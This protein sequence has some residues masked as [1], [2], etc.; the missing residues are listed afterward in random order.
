MRDNTKPVELKNSEAKSLPLIGNAPITRAHHW[1]HSLT[2]CGLGVFGVLTVIAVGIRTGNHLLTLALAVGFLL[3]LAGALFWIY[4]RKEV[5]SRA[6]L[7]AALLSGAIVSFSILGFQMA[8]E[9]QRQRIAEREALQLSLTMQPDLS[10]VAL[11]GRDL[12]Q[13]LLHGKRLTK[14]VMEHTNF[15]AADLSC[16]QMDGAKLDGANLKGA[17]LTGARFRHAQ[18]WDTDLRNSDLY[19]ANFQYADLSSARFDDDSHLSYT[20]FRKAILDGATFAGAYVGGIDEDDFEGPADLRGASL[21]GADF[22]HAD[23]SGALLKGAL[24]DQSTKWPS[25][26]NPAKAGVIS[27]SPDKESQFVAVEPYSRPARDC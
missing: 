27:T 4:G 6:T 1:S 8:T 9:A 11:S 26:F 7:G 19:N 12:S 14:A 23:L 2:A 22:S 20:D 10:G 25:G 18:V 24:A 3:I 16:G 17:N 21:V 13:F 5:G 15:Q